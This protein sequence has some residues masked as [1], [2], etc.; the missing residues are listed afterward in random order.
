MTDAS[1]FLDRLERS[2][3]SSRVPTPLGT[4]VWR[5]WG[6]QSPLLRPL[7]LLHGGSGSWRHWARNILALSD[8]RTVWVP[9][10]PG[11]GDSDT[12]AAPPERPDVAGAVI[13]A[14]GTLIATQSFD[15]A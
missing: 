2:A 9:D 4:M 6:T 13:A 14:L 1:G 12:P 15:L 5:R 7:L 10:L 8:V 11:I 3:T